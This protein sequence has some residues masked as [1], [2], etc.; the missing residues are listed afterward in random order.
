MMIAVIGQQSLQLIASEKWAKLKTVMPRS[1]ELVLQDG[2]TL[3][4]ALLRFE[5]KVRQQPRKRKRALL[6]IAIEGVKA[7]SPE[8]QDAIAEAILADLRRDADPSALRFQAL[9]E[10][11]YTRGLTPAESLEIDG[12]EA[13]F[14]GSDEVFYGP[15]IA[16]ARA[17]KS[18]AG[19]RRGS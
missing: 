4:S 12:L 13:A 5:R 19:K 9:I 10:A 17:K 2:E 16:R 3:E 7:L 15:I 14:R 1:I 18:A 11:K 6:D 8:R